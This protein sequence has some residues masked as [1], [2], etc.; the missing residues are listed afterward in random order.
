M[1]VYLIPTTTSGRYELYYEAPDEDV[2]DDADEGG[3]PNRLTFGGFARVKRRF[4][5]LLLEAEEWRHRRHEAQPDA[6][7]F[8]V[9]LRRRIMGFIVERIAEQR[10][11]WHLRKVTEVCASIPAD[12]QESEADAV[13]RAILKAD[14]DRH[15]K[16][17]LIDFALLIPAAALTVVPGPNVLGLYFLF[18]VVSHYLSWAGA[19]RGLAIS[20]WTFEPSDD[21]T[22]LRQAMTL[23]SP[24]RQRTFHEIAARL[25]LEHL[26]TFLDDVAA[27][28]A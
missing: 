24:H 3:L 14:H 2:V 22:A 4:S 28:R 11:L 6:A 7:G 16:W 10:L 26:P 20:P 15:R 23:G 18:Q 21:L 5:E 27:R 13:I 17:F 19:R 9:R 25:H 12:V 1:N 8:L